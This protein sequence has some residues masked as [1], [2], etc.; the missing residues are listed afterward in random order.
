MCVCVCKTKGRRPPP[1]PGPRFG[2]PSVQ[3]KSSWMIFDFSEKNSCLVSRGINLV[4]QIFL[5]LLNSIFHVCTNTTDLESRPSCLLLIHV[6]ILWQQKVLR[7]HNVTFTISSV[8]IST[9]IQRA[10]NKF[11]YCEHHNEQF[12]FCINL[13]VRSTKRRQCSRKIYI[14]KLKCYS[15]WVLRPRPPAYIC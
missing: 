3:F 7:I 15:L 6:L 10:S 12:F 11:G 5:A 2:D 8:T 14:L 9:C 1:L 4:F 13:F